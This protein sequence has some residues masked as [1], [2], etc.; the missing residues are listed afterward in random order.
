LQQ[1]CLLDLNGQRL[2]RSVGE[3]RFEPCEQSFQFMTL[4]NGRLDL[5]RRRADR[6]QRRIGLDELL[7]VFDRLLDVD[8][9]LDAVGLQVVIRV[10]RLG[11]ARTGLSSSS[12]WDGAVLCHDAHPQES[13]VRRLF[14]EKLP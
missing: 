7:N 3:R 6:H 11:S 12:G 9:L 2:R 14:D 10:E 13:V 4:Q 5:K 1:R 8:V